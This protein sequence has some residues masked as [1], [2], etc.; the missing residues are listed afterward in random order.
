MES[1]AVENVRGALLRSVEDGETVLIVVDRG[2]EPGV[3]D[4]L[5]EA[6]R[7]LRLSHNVVS[8][9]VSP[10]PNAEPPEQVADA[11]LQHNVIVVGTTVPIAHTKAVRTANAEGARFISMDGVNLAMLTGGG[12]SAD[13]S[14]IHEIGLAIEERWN[15][16]SHVRVTSELGTDLEADITGRRSWRFD[17]TPFRADWFLLTGCAFPDGE[18]GI[19]PLEGTANGTVVWDASVHWLGLLRDLIRLEVK[20]GWVKAI[21]GGDQAKELETRLAE[22]DDANSYYCPAEIAIGINPDAQ[23][24]GT[25]REDKKAL[26]TV[27]IATGTNIDIGGTIEAKSHIDGLIR[28]PSVWLDGHTIVDN[29]QIAPE[30]LS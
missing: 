23:I 17:G 10:V 20:K 26:G 24:T 15:A 30:V 5:T 22:L 4:V 6:A 27:H 2:T 7:G 16:A 14:R 1:S 9:P 8:M 25:M 11:M 29:G 3:T 18:V 21:S 28:Q 13:Y 12:A 19:A